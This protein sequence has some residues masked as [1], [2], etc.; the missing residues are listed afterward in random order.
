M[1]LFPIRI[2]KLY[3]L[4]L[5]N[6]ISFSIGHVIRNCWIRNYQRWASFQ[7]LKRISNLSYILQLK[8]WCFTCLDDSCLKIRGRVVELIRASP[9]NNPVFFLKIGFA[10]VD[11]PK[12][13]K[14]TV[15]L[16]LG[17][18]S[19]QLKLIDQQTLLYSI[20][21]IK[22]CSLNKRSLRKLWSSKR[23]VSRRIV[24][25]L[26]EWIRTRRKRFAWKHP[27][28]IKRPNIFTSS[29]DKWNELRRP[30]RY[31]NF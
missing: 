30:K 22:H 2:L 3:T 23:S 21:S 9:I 17:P 25:L 5:G 31:S 26:K 24:S 18:I 12:S 6:K 1:Y 28:G 4:S 10:I 14:H 7:M 29:K 20:S 19:R 8:L 13:F 11:G 16:F 15:C 27:K